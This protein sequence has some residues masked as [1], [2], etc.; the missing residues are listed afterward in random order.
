M[1]FASVRRHK[2]F[3]G[4]K[5]RTKLAISKMESILTGRCCGSMFILRAIWES[6]LNAS[7]PHN[8]TSNTIHTT[9]V[10]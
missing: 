7:F 8:N 5:E 9:A 1:T 6:A 3:C 10:K 4:H 2:A